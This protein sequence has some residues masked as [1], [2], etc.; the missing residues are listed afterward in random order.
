MFLPPEPARLTRESSPDHAMEHPKKQEA[1]ASEIKLSLD[2]FEVERPLGKGM[3]GSVSLAKHRK[4]GFICVLKVLQ[5]K[6]MSL[7]RTEKH[8]RREIEIHSN[9]RHPNILRF[10]NWFH[11][12]TRIFIVLEFAVGG[13]LHEVLFN[14]GTPGFTEARAAKYVAQVA[15]AL[16]YLHSKNIM[17]RDIKPENILLG[18]YDEVKLADFGYSAY[19]PSNRRVT[20][21]G[22]LDF[23]PPEMLATDD[24]PYGREVDYWTLGCLAFELLTGQA[25]FAHMKTEETERKI[26]ALEIGEFPMHISSEA[27]NFV[28]MVRYVDQ[29]LF[30]LPC[31]HRTPSRTSILTW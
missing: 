14:E 19:S 22:T 31:G 6:D 3:F 30:T 18:P 2:Q 11:D 20:R 17:H 5:K 4:S 7:D 27:R 16:R 28:L 12:E 25:P 29:L 9:L 13:A 21:C 23:M 15:D 8:C 26:Q 10:F 1:V 24:K